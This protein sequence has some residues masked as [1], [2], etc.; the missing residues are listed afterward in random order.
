MSFIEIIATVFIVCV[1]L[2]IIILKMMLDDAKYEEE[3]AKKY[4][5]YIFTDGSKLMTQSDEN[6]EKIKN[7]INKHGQIITVINEFE[8]ERKED[9][10]DTK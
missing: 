5:L 3:Q 6:S 8:E 1:M 2:S 9:E 7:E 10:R 4:R